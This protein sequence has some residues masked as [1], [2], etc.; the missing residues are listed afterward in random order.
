MTV[1]VLSKL[2]SWTK[3]LNVYIWEQIG[4]LKVRAKE[5]S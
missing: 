3:W 5:F 4:Q 1:E 2:K